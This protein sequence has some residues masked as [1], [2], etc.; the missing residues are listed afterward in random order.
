MYFMPK[1][2][3]STVRDRATLL[4]RAHDPGCEV[5]GSFSRN[6]QDCLAGVRLNRVSCRATDNR[7]VNLNRE[8]AVRN[9]DIPGHIQFGNG[10]AKFRVMNARK[11]GRDLS[12]R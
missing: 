4:L 12:L 11:P 2:V 7:Q 9:G 1:K 6:C 10:K 8:T 5:E 3:D